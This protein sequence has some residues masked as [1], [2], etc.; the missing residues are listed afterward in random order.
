MMV[1]QLVKHHSV[2]TAGLLIGWL[3]ALVLAAVLLGLLG[4]HSL[5]R[6]EVSPWTPMPVP[7][8]PPGEHTLPDGIEVAELQIGTG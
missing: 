5:P 1:R 3:I 8:L 7:T 6:R 2:H 4:G